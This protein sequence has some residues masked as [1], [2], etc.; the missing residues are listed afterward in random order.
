ML[1]IVFVF[2]LLLLLS[3]PAGAEEEAPSKS[4]P[5]VEE[6]LKALE[7]R[8]DQLEKGEEVR[9]PTEYVCPDGTVYDAPHGCREGGPALEQVSFRKLKFSRRESLAEKIAGELEQSQRL[10]LGGSARGILQGVLG[11]DDRDQLFATGAVDLY[12]FT[13]PLPKSAL[14]IDLESLGGRGPDQAVGSL[15]R[16]NREADALTVT[17]DLK[18]R[19]AW[20]LQQFWDD[21]LYLVGGKID[22]TNYFD[23]NGV[24][25]DETTA[26]LNGALVNNPLLAQ[27]ING[28]GGAVLFN[29]KGDLGGRLGMQ[30]SDGSSRHFAEKVY[31]IAEIDY[32]AHPMQTLTGNYRLW[33]QTS[34]VPSDLSRERWGVGISIDQ[35]VQARTALFARYAVGRTEGENDHS[36]AGS[37]GFAVYAPFL[38]RARDHTGIGFGYINT[39]AGTEKVVEG[40][41]HLFVTYQFSLIANVQWLIE[42]PNRTTGGENDHLVIP[43]IRGTANF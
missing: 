19:E 31:A 38:D 28:P 10:K 13:A 4:P 20:L 8:L 35:K 33:G 24:A 41:Y 3:A 34:R 12:F 21:R 30:S 6:R 43:G 40:Y 37:A 26:F 11:T 23:Q 2:L 29:P 18:V 17:D 7:R 27:P 39:A 14:L 25:N 22:L 1:R 42:G 32:H 15:S 36:T 9:P 5:P 16:L